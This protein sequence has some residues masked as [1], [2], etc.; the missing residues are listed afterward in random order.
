MAR[1]LVGIATKGTIDPQA[2]VAAANLDHGEHEVVYTYANGRGVYGAAQVRNDLAKQ[3][4]AGEYDYL[5]SIDSDTIVPKN[6]LL[7]L[8]EQEPPIMLGVYRYKRDTGD[9]PFFMENDSK[10]VWND[11]PDVRFPIKAGGLGCSL[12]AVD[13]LLN[14]PRPAFHWDER[15]TGHHT[16]EDIWFC[17][18]ARD[19]GYR[20]Y[21]D[22]RVK[23]GHAGRVVFE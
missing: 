19:A 1:V 11:I 8:I 15:P 4:I 17:R 21:A 10:L 9:A 18:Q 22:G 16:S 20:I 5:L 7:L 6:A 2:A 3:A 14:L 23:C 12:I 13:V